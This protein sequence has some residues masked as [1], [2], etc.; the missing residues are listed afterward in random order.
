MESL[1]T[2]CVRENENLARAVKRAGRHLLQQKKKSE[3]CVEVHDKKKP[4]VC[5]VKGRALFNKK[6]GNACKH[7]CLPLALKDSAL[8]F[9]CSGMFGG[10]V[11]FSG[12]SLLTST[13]QSPRKR[14]T[15]C[16]QRQEQIARVSGKTAWGCEWEKRAAM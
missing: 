13:G 2:N 12:S 10:G 3:N 16:A 15:S 9:L 1:S 4:G 14:Y 7:S 6:S 5:R 11:T 8:I